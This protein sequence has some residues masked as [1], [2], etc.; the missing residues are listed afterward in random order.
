MPLEIWL[1]DVMGEDS[2]LEKVRETLGLKE[3]P[4]DES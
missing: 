2:A 1:K 3:E 4:A